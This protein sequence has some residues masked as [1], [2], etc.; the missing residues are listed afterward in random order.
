MLASGT[1][2]NPMPVVYESK[3]H[4]H[5]AIRD[6]KRDKLLEEIEEMCSRA[7]DMAKTESNLRKVMALHS[8]CE[9]LVRPRPTVNNDAE[10][11]RKREGYHR[12]RKEMLESTESGLV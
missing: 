7:K 10:R 3:Q 1:G 8:R 5:S 11:A 4:M 12:R 2:Q 6:M 9:I